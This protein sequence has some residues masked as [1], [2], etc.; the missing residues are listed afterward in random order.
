M[1]LAQTTPPREK[2]TRIE[3]DKPHNVCAYCRVSTD[4]EDQINSYKAQVSFYTDHI[5]TNPKWNFAG[6]Y[7]DEGIT[8]TIASKRTRFMDMIRDCEKGKIDL[9]LTKS[10]SR[11]ARNTVDSLKYIRNLKAMGI[12]V[13]FEVLWGGCSEDEKEFILNVLEKSFK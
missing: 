13:F 1:P 11:F 9:I 7:A 6:I 12:G 10:V 3:D 4:E 2:P 5:C 8:G